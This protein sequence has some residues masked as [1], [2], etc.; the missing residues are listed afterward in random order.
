MKKKIIDYIT[1]GGK[2]VLSSLLKVK[3][4]V[5]KVKK[6]KKSVELEGIS[7]NV[8]IQGDISGKLIINVSEKTGQKIAEKYLDEKVDKF[9]LDLIESV[10]MEITNMV[11][12]RIITYFNN[13]GNLKTTIK[14]PK[15]HKQNTLETKK[16]NIDIVTIPIKTNLGNIL[17]ICLLQIKS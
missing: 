10:I 8:G 11:T 13:N 9:N 17:M 5:L 14:I 16:G 2:E 15:I 12:G 3:S 6:T 7:I 4:T 1:K